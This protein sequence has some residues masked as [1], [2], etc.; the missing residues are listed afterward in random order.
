MSDFSNTPP[1]IPY[2]FHISVDSTLGAIFIGLVLS[3]IFYGI[4]VL[5]TILYVRRLYS[6]GS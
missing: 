2:G 6:R 1:A 4:T 3:S 5:Q